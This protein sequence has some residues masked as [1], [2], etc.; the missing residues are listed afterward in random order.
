MFVSHA[1]QQQHDGVQ[2]L[3][4]SVVGPERHDEVVEAVSCTLRRHNDQLV[5]EAVGAGILERTVVASLEEEQRMQ[6]M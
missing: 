5:F 6:L 3:S 1:L 4:G 2:L